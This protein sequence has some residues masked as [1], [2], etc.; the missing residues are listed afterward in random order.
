MRSLFLLACAS[1]ALAV[2][3]ASPLGAQEEDGFREFTDKRG[4][5][6]S[7]KLLGISEDRRTMNIVRA[8][9]K[10]FG[11][12]INQLSLDDQQYIKDWLKKRPETGTSLAASST[13]LEVSMTR[14][15]G[16]TRKRRSANY[17]MEEKD[18]L[19]RVTLKNLS[20]DALTSARIEYAVVW[21]NAVTVFENKDI[22][23]WS[24]HLHTNTNV[25]PRTKILGSVAL[26]NLRFNGEFSFD[27]APVSIDRVFYDGNELYQE[28]EL[29]G[30]KVRV[31]SVNGAVILDRDSGGSGIGA[32]TWEELPSLAD[33]GGTN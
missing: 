9:G 5:K 24:F 1:A 4:Q 16:E 25:S 10:A 3:S 22:G 18:N 14:T 21:N 32:T 8:D 19:Y 29:L 11:A 13:R 12:I 23:E 30:L 6:M 27:T 33:P 15:V 20:R 17:G 26:E 7:A 28:D 2:S 31:V